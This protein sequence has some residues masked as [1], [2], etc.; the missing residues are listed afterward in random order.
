VPIRPPNGREIHI[1]SAG[2]DDDEYPARLRAIDWEGLFSNNRLGNYLEATRR[3]WKSSYDFVLV[4]S[5]T[6]VTDSGGICTIHLPDV[7]VAVFTSNEQSL[8]GV[9]KVLQSAR[10]GHSKLPVDRR[11]LVV[12]PVPSRDESNSEHDMAEQWRERFSSELADFFKDWAPSGERNTT[13]LNLLK[14]PYLPYWSFGERIPVLEQED[15]D[16]PKTLAYSYQPLARLLRSG[17]NWKE[18]REG[19]QA[20]EDAQRLAAEAEKS[21]LEAA[22][23][24]HEAQERAE[25]KERAELER[26]EKERAGRVAALEERVNSERARWQ[27]RAKI[28]ERRGFAAFGVGLFVA[29]GLAWLARVD[30]GLSWTYAIGIGV[31]I[32]FIGIV[33]SGSFFTKEDSAKAISE[34]LLRELQSYKSRAQSY[35]SLGADEAVALLSTNIDEN[36]QRGLKEFGKGNKFTWR[37]ATVQPESGPKPTTTPELNTMVRPAAVKLQVIDSSSG[38]YVYDIYVSYQRTQILSDWLSLFLPLLSGWLSEDLGRDARIFWGDDTAL[39]GDGSFLDTMQSA[40]RASR[41]LLPVLTPSYFQ[42]DFCMAELRSFTK[43]ERR[44]I[45][46]I[47]FRGNLTLPEDMRR[48]QVVDMSQFAYAGDAFKTS[49]RY[50]DFQKTV[51]EMSPRLVDA[52]RNAPPFDPNAPVIL[53]GDVKV[54]P[55]GLQL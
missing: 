2:K 49:P 42:S 10:R 29:I 20:T 16:N 37:S 44:P 46:P 50:L 3:E 39:A 34:G 7:L 4:D 36:L 6:G 33:T 31:F 5:R 27:E 38:D 53:P 22:R 48:F 51:Q 47:L 54:E 30:V 8:Q 24:A 32:G 23:L 41:C 25:M 15:P 19:T 11:K 45:V 18:A 1:L 52:I 9:R 14:I 35:A 40:L 12:V 26:V 55:P 21:R 43:W 13:I 28:S 17:L